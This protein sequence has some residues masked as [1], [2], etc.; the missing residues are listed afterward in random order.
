[1]SKE[2]VRK[3]HDIY[4]AFNKGDYSAVIAALDP[5]VEWRMAENFIYT[6][7]KPKLGPQAVLEG[8]RQIAKDW[9]DFAVSPEV[10]HDAGDAVVAEGYYTGTHRKSGKDVRAQFAHF[11]KLRNGRVTEFQQYTDT[12]QFRDAVTG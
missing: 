1:M 11:Y 7:E 9:E 6:G 3:I 12:A 2:N 10:L 8:F 4:E 5:E